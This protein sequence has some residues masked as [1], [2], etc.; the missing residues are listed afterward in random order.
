MALFKL[1]KGYRVV[2]TEL[3][4]RV[5]D[6]TGAEIQ[7]N[8]LE[9]Q[10]LARARIAGL[11]HDAPTLPTVIRKL[12]QLGVLEQAGPESQPT[13][14]QTGPLDDILDGLSIEI[15][16]EPQKATQPASASPARATAPDQPHALGLTAVPPPLRSDLQIDPEQGGL[17]SITNPTSGKTFTLYDFEASLARMLDGARTVAQI[18]EGGGRLGIPVDLASINQFLRQLERY[19]FLG[20]P[21]VKGQ[22]AP[23]SGPW[24]AR[25]RWDESLRSMYQAG[26]RLIRQ[27]RYAEAVPY[28]EAMLQQSPEN[29]EAAEMLAEAR[30]RAQVELAADLRVTVAEAEPIEVTLNVGPPPKKRSAPKR[31]TL[32]AAALGLAGFV[33]LVAFAT[34]QRSAES[35]ADISAHPTVQRALEAPAPTAASSPQTPPGA[36]SS[37][38]LPPRG[39][40]TDEVAATDRPATALPPD[41]PAVAAAAADSP[42]VTGPTPTAPAAAADAPDASAA[43]APAAATD[44]PAPAAPAAVADAPAAP[45]PTAPAAD[46]PASPTTATEAA[47]PATNPVAEP[48]E[49]VMGAEPN[50]APSRAALG[51][52]EPGSTI[53]ATVERRGRATMGQLAAPVFGELEREVAMEQRVKRN[54]TIGALKGRGALA[55][56]ISGLVMW[57]VEDGA[58]VAAGHLVAKILYHEA[59]VMGFLPLAAPRPEKSWRCALDVPNQQ[60]ESSCLITGIEKRPRGWYVTVTAEPTWVERSDGLRLRLTPPR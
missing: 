24:P 55:A 38:A 11:R 4:A 60:L 39:A 21:R 49:P 23:A 34:V 45:A 16:P 28:F 10:I 18:L 17:V 35:P 48:P 41:A 19:G 46:A 44:A 40:T 7:L 33:G 13:L 8:P 6:P 47:E 3:G 1:G 42:G 59:Y 56:P 9:V 51:A 12:A 30:L 57:Q 26:V 58:H 32:A 43:A 22:P 15:A 20:P 29:P 54:Q 52:D 50:A 53:E 36:D 27:G 5:I 2:S 25:Q 31:A 37:A 14:P